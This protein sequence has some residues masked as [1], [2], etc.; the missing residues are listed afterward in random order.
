LINIHSSTTLHD[1]TSVS[2]LVNN[3][4]I[5]RHSSVG[6]IPRD[7][8]SVE[9]SAEDVAGCALV[10]EVPALSPSVRTPKRDLTTTTTTKKRVNIEIDKK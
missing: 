6:F 4:I 10:A 8:P 5:S 7:L 3:N 2:T 9:T 1:V